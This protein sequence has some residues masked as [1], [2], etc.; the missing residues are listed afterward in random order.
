MLPVITANKG[1]CSHWSYS[2]STGSPGGTQDGSIM[3]AIASP[4]TAGAPPPPLTVHP[5]ETQAEKAQDRAPGS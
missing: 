4:A 3:P 1:S 2:H 5:E